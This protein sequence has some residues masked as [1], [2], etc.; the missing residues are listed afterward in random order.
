MPR[1]HA[2]TL[3]ITLSISLTACKESGQDSGAGTPP[4]LTNVSLDP[5]E[6]TEATVVSCV[7]TGWWDPDGDPE[8][9]SFRWLVNGEDVGDGATLDGSSFDKG[10]AVICEATPTDGVHDG[11]PVQSAASTVLNTP[12]VVP[13]AV[14]DPDPPTGSDPVYVIFPGAVDADG[15]PLQA[16]LRWYVNGA[17][18]SDQLTLDPEIFSRGDSIYALVSVSD[19]DSEE[20]VLVTE[21]STVANALPIASL[22]RI[23]PEVA[24]ASDTLEVEV[25]AADADGDSFSLSYAWFINNVQVSNYGATLS[26]PQ[27]LSRDDAVYVVV[28][29]NDGVGT[30]PGVAS[31]ILYVANSAPVAPEVD[32]SPERPGEGL[33]PLVCEPGES[34]DYDGDPVTLSVRWEVDGAPF[35]G[36]TTTNLTGDTVPA[37]EQHEGEVWTCFAR[38]SDGVDQGEEGSKSF[39]IGPAW[40]ALEIDGRTFNISGGTHDYSTVRVVNGGRLN[41]SG[42]VTLRA[43]SI[44]VDSTSIIDGLGG[45]Y[46]GGVAEAAADG[47]GRGGNGG[48]TLSTAHGGGGGGHGGAG[49][50]GGADSTETPASGGAVN[51]YDDRAYATRGS[52]GGGGGINGGDGG[53]GGAALTLNAESIEI[54]GTLDLSG[55][56]GT[57]TAIYNAGGGGAGGTILLTCEDL[58]LRGTAELLVRGGDGGNGSSQNADGGGGGGGGRIKIFYEG[59]FS[60]NSGYTL[61]LSGGAGGVGRAGGTTT[62]Q[63]G[64]T[65]VLYTE[66]TE[67]SP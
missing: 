57:A 44:Y 10:D 3:T 58:S 20:Q 63:A 6:I 25:E 46:S 27:W 1:F 23:N 32:A 15:D 9:Y 2:F 52:G 40:S 59:N 37:A 5:A 28:T 12:P 39:T 66:I 53:D 60:T 49:G 11:Q 41:V 7:P 48:S 14:L 21:T 22:V 38:G 13:V 36:T 24:R 42:E 64:S 34:E 29:A 17:E 50:Q 61:D 65:G 8:A 16:Q 26:G 54:A 67:Y 47:S 43:T 31:S 33:W 45:G 18:V 62:G 35:S 55:D 30:G 4:S 51:G 56:Q 19:G